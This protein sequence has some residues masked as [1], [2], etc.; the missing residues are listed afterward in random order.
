MKEVL[1]QHEVKYAYV[2]ICES[3]GS[4]KKFLTIRDTAPEYEEVR[5]THRAG[6]P[7]IV[8]DD[9]VILVHGASHMEELIKEYKLCEA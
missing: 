8:I 6:I 3:V 9:Q 5:Q 2:D 7:M 1:S 4:L